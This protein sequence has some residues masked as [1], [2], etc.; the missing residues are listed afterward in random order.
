MADQAEREIRTQKEFSESAAGRDFYV[1]RERR[2]KE[3]VDRSPRSE[4]QDDMTPSLRH[5]FAESAK[6]RAAAGWEL[7]SN[8]PVKN[9]REVVE[10]ISFG[11]I[12]DG[13]KEAYNERPDQRPAEHLRTVFDGLIARS[14]AERKLFR[15]RKR[16]DAAPVRVPQ[17][18]RN[19]FLDK[20]APAPRTV[21]ASDP[22][23]WMSRL[24]ILDE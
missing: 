9:V 17:S 5:E 12:V 19:A 8:M 7:A 22:P 10:A 3:T 14:N 2:I 1:E 18:R 24:P 11:A 23:S 4:A 15:D 6:R 16:L 13:F 20:R 21:L